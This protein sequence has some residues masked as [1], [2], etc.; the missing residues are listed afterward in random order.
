MASIFDMLRLVEKSPESYLIYLNEQRDLQLRALMILVIGYSSAL[1]V[2]GIQESLIHFTDRFG[3][4][5]RSRFGWSM[6]GGPIGA[7]LEHSPNAD[8]AWERFWALLWEF[9]KSLN[10][11]AD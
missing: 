1:R 4:H 3:R 6:S 2:H 7:I 11:P 10:L 9:E 5:L 8:A